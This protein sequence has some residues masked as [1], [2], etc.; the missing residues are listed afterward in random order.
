MRPSILPILATTLLVGAP[1]AAQTLTGAPCAFTFN[2]TPVQILRTDAGALVP[3]GLVPA[4]AIQSLPLAIGTPA[5][6]SGV[7][8][9]VSRPGGPRTAHRELHLTY[10]SKG[11]S[12]YDLG[13]YGRPA[14]RDEGGE[15]RCQRLD[16]RD[17]DALL[18]TPSTLVFNE[19]LRLVFRDWEGVIFDF[20]AFRAKDLVRLNGAGGLTQAPPAGH[21][22]VQVA[23]AGS[24]NVFFAD[25]DGIIWRLWQKGEGWDFQKLS[26][27]GAT[28]AP[29][30]L[31]PLAAFCCGPSLHLVY[32]DPR[33]A[34]FDLDFDLERSAWGLRQLNEDG[35]GAT[36]APLAAAQAS[37]IACLAGD[38]GDY[39]VA[40]RT[41]DGAII[42]IRRQKGAFH[43]DQL[44]AGGLTSSPK[45]RHDPALQPQ[46]SGP[47]CLLTYV[48][49][50]GDLTLLVEE[51]GGKAWSS[52]N[53]VRHQDLSARV[54]PGPRS[55]PGFAL[56]SKDAGASAAAPA[57]AGK[58]AAAKA[59]QVAD[60]A[61][62]LN[63]LL[64]KWAEKQSD[65][66]SSRID[67][68]KLFGRDL[69]RLGDQVTKWF[70]KL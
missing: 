43:A 40:Y 36:K 3:E 38:S 63:Q 11:G 19:E 68:G 57:P 25:A 66:A 32:A 62:G 10:R 56:E 14:D 49:E 12:L 9:S 58:P 45:A 52:V 29:A 64:A 67:Q 48:D 51:G 28:Q 55:E 37:P 33:G 8:T 4:E 60:A 18:G 24:R 15:W 41:A 26:N 2:G 7:V 35:V 34:I 50:A 20:P 46:G 27:G 21:D 53:L 13:L 65:D 16:T 54:K 59:G 6:A 42:Q 47:G 31:G 30:A 39:R 61:D 69:V 17:C 44:N 5:A 1:A 23:V 22:P 70:K